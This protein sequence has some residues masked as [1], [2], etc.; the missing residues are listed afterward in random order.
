MQSSIR[1]RFQGKKFNLSCLGV[2]GAVLLTIVPTQD[3]AQSPI[4]SSLWVL[5]HLGIGSRA[6]TTNGTEQF[7]IVRNE[8]FRRLETENGSSNS[9]KELEPAKGN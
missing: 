2:V 1:A 3:L 9:R 7:V 6:F 8:G 4:N 5:E